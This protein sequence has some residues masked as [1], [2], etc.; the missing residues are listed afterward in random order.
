MSGDSARAASPVGEQELL[1]EG[2][3]EF[4]ICFE[5]DD[6]EDGLL[7]PGV[8]GNSS[9]HES[10][11]RKQVAFLKSSSYSMRVR[12]RRPLYGTAK[13]EEGEDVSAALVVLD[14]AFVRLGDRNVRF[15]TAN[16]SFDFQDAATIGLNPHDASFD[17]SVQ[18]EVLHWEPRTFIGAV[19]QF[20]EKRTG[21]LGLTL[22]EPLN[23]AGVE[24]KLAG[25]S[26]NVK[27]HFF[28]IQSTREEEAESCVRWILQEKPKDGLPLYEIPL[29]AIVRC[30]PG[31]KFI[32]KVRVEATI[33]LSWGQ[34]SRI[35]GEKDGPLP[36]THPNE[37]VER[38][39]ETELE[40]FKR[41]DHLFDRKV[42]LRIIAG[43]GDIAV[44]TPSDT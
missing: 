14:F 41:L 17:W 35:A 1:D 7:G 3:F 23:I 34:I 20:V 43:T 15:K 28:S 31:R 16:I 27:D 2:A 13:N 21:Q 12:C 19:T 29:A 32:A 40:A 42:S 39:L 30:I 6:Y 33:R 18:P 36:F 11:P 10:Q 5:D 37:R 25:V 22:S 26:A 8:P 44:E 9:A 24:A 4:S 38:P